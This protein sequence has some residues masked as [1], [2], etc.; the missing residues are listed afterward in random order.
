MADREQNFQ[1]CR[2]FGVSCANANEC[3]GLREL[4]LSFGITSDS[5]KT[6]VQKNILD[7]EDRTHKYIRLHCRCSNELI[8]RLEKINEIAD[9]L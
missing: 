6:Q 5:T 3:V 7:L 9:Q 2:A 1:R 8:R 4:N